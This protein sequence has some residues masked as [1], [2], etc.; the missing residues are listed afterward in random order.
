[1][2]RRAKAVKGKLEGL[3]RDNATS[4]KVPDCGPR[5]STDR[6]RTSVIAG[7]DKKLKDVMDD[8]QITNKLIPQVI[9]P[10]AT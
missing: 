2:L 5:S 3:D 1:M 8:F 9:N 4:R 7:L 6:T 10:W